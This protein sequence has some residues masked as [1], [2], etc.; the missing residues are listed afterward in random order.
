MGSRILKR[1]ISDTGRGSIMWYHYFNSIG[2]NIIGNNQNSP[3]TFAQFIINLNSDEKFKLFYSQTFFFINV[4]SRKE[5]VELIDQ[6][7]QNIEE[8]KDYLEKH[9]NITKIE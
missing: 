2:E 3:I 6:I 1:A 7:I 5:S 4:L 9:I 8:C